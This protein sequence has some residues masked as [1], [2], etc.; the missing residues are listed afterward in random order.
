MDG[1]CRGSSVISMILH[2]IWLMNWSV[3]A[4]VKIEYFENVN[5]V[6]IIQKLMHIDNGWMWM[7]SL[8]LDS[9]KWG[10]ILKRVWARLSR[11]DDANRLRW[12]GFT[13]DLVNLNRLRRMMELTTSW[14]IL[15]GSRW[16]GWGTNFVFRSTSFE[17]LSFDRER[18]WDSRMNESRN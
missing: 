11:S 7:L 3:V 2:S 15:A 5:Q 8:F 1:I 16:L 17:G 12:D 14:I 6:E 10:R 9:G 18:H 4:R 13:V